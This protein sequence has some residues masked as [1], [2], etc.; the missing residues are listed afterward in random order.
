MGEYYVQAGRG[1]LVAAEGRVHQQFI[2]GTADYVHLVLSAVPWL[3]QSA[4][5][6]V[7]G[8]LD[9]TRPKS[10]GLTGITLA[11]LQA[12]GTMPLH[13]DAGAPSTAVTSRG[14]WARLSRPGCN[15]NRT[16]PGALADL[17]GQSTFHSNLVTARLATADS[18]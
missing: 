1:P 17:A 7:R 6:T 13:A 8:V 2:T 9:A 11:W 18:A 15:I 14:L 16:T 10:P 5:V 12:E 3:Y 4:E